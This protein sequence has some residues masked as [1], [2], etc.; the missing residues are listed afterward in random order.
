MTRKSPTGIVVS[1]FLLFTGLGCA[2]LPSQASGPLPPGSTYV[3]HCPGIAGDSSFDRRWTQSLVDGRAAHR[4]EICD[5]TCS[6]H[7]LTAL[8]SVDRHHSKAKEIAERITAQRAADPTGRVMITSESAGCGVALFAL[9]AL[10]PDVTVDDVILVSPAVS[11]EFDLSPALAHVRGKMYYFDSPIDV[12]TLG[13]GTG[14]F[15]TIDQK[16]CA[17][18]GLVGFHS[19]AATWA[20]H[21][22]KLVEMK[23]DFAWSRWGYLGT[24]LSGM[25]SA[26]ALH[27]VA[28]M[29]CHDEQEMAVADV[30]NVQVQPAPR[31]VAML[32]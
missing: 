26:W 27:V 4:V 7:W 16:K 19:P 9:A 25:S 17:S 20:E 2:S 29:L 18:A 32:R 21:Y 28:P 23:Y 1:L 31:R 15:G 10:P 5:W 6:H 22:N 8:Y 12:L 13:L 11:P 24:H 30:R 14:I 3:F